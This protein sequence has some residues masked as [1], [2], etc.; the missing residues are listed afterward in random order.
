MGL[1]MRINFIFTFAAISIVSL[2]YI[3]NFVDQRLKLE[4]EISNL[5]NKDICEVFTLKKQLKT[6]S[7]KKLYIYEARKRELFCSIKN[8]TVAI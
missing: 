7:E 8:S 2:L 3:S 1:N 5:S 6:F 4:K